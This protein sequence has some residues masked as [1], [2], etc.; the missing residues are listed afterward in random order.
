MNSE[1]QTPL[2]LLTDIAFG[3]TS[4]TADFVKESEIKS[5]EIETGLY[6]AAHAIRHVIDRIG[7]VNYDGAHTD[8]GI[9]A[10]AANQI[11]LQ[12]EEM[13]ELAHSYRIFIGKHVK[14]AA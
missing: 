1:P 4:L 9:L 3:N 6:N 10:C 8:I 12:T 13:A 7:E 2:Q 5:D 14:G 11:N